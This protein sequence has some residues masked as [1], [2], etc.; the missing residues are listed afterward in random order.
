MMIIV[1]IMSVIVMILMKK[2]HLCIDGDCG[3]G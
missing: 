3:A 1:K 2:L